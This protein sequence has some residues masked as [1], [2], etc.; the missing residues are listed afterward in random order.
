MYMP[1]ATANP[2]HAGPTAR[3]PSKP[4][5]HNSKRKFRHHPLR[6][7]CHC[8]RQLCDAHYSREF[9]CPEPSCHGPMEPWRTRSKPSLRASFHNMEK[10]RS[11]KIASTRAE[12]GVTLV[13]PCCNCPSVQ[14]FIWT[15]LGRNVKD[16]QVANKFPGS[17]P[18]CSRSTF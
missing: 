10:P 8:P 15:T 16:P 5:A 17:S 1:E 2:D 6:T 13:K 12:Q 4:Q 18:N 3:G 11:A 7:L 9:P 14:K